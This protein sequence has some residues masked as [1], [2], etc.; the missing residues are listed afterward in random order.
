QLKGANNFKT[1]YWQGYEGKDIEALV[2]LGKPELVNQ[3]SAGF[4]Q[5]LNSWI[6]FPKQVDFYSSDNGKTFKK[7]KQI[8][9]DFSL[10]QEGSYIKEFGFKTHLKTRYVKM[11]A[12]NM[13]PCPNWHVGAGGKSWLFADEIT[14]E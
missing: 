8:E 9:N 6:W 1:G 7:I 14:I 5:D 12:K 10:R 4:L 13:G 11:I 3:I 2:D